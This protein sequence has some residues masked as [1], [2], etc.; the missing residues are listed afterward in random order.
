MWDQLGLS[1]GLQCCKMPSRRHSGLRR[2]RGKS[3]LG[4]GEP[5]RGWG[6]PR[7][8]HVL[9]PRPGQGPHSHTACSAVLSEAVSSGL[10]HVRANSPAACSQHSTEVNPRS[11][12]LSAEQGQCVTWA[13]SA[14]PGNPSLHRVRSQPGCGG[15]GLRTFPKPALLRSGR[16]TGAAGRRG[17]AS[18]PP[19]RR[20][21]ADCGPLPSSA[22]GFIQEPR[23]VCEILK[24]LDKTQVPS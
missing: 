19:Q 4:R 3:R 16:R 12:A 8:T 15:S 2:P 21:P 10:R 14:P 5:A 1:W 24:N 6:C 7:Q 11:P 9:L 20:R 17:P 13:R 23:F 22:G 18:P